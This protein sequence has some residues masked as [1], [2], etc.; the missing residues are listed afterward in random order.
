MCILRSTFQSGRR[1]FA[2]HYLIYMWNV[3]IC[4]MFIKCFWQQIVVWDFKQLRSRD[5]RRQANSCTN[6]TSPIFFHKDWNISLT[7]QQKN[8][9][10]LVPL[11]LRKVGG[12]IV[13]GGH[14]IQLQAGSR[15][16]LAS[17]CSTAKQSPGVPRCQGWCQPCW[18]RWQ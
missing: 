18:Q 11:S 1:L 13:P 12:V 16:G 6:L 4:D 5:L 10:H 8:S 15:A 14:L 7:V 2:I 9:L 17:N 3:H